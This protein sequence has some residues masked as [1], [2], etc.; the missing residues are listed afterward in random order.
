MIIV[1]EIYLRYRSKVRIGGYKLEGKTEMLRPVFPSDKKIKELKIDALQDF[2]KF[3]NFLN[4]KSQI[5]RED[6]IRFCN[7]WGP[8]WYE[9]E[10]AAQ[11]DAT[12]LGLKKAQKDRDAVMLPK[13]DF[14]GVDIPFNLGELQWAYTE[15]GRLVP[16]IECSH[17]AHA[18]MALWVFSANDISIEHKICRFYKHYG[19]RKGCEKFFQNSRANKQFCSPNCKSA[20]KKKQD[21]RGKV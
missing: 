21:W 11:F 17:L 8:L 20:F 1:G 19:I 15:E 2:F 18:L 7:K 5:A 12:F 14:K 13:I 16:T 3:G 4:K 9:G 6:R 10:S